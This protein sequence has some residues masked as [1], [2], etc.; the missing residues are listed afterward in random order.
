MK[1]ILI[2]L[3]SLFL[4]SCEKKEEPPCA[5]G[6]E[7]PQENLEWLK[8]QLEN[9]FCTEIYL[10][11][12]NDKEYIGIYD[13]PIGA[14]MGFVIYNC[15]GTKYCQY[16]GL[17]GQCDCTANFLENATKTLIYKQTENPKFD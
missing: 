14:D 8:Q 6:V 4:I 5:C 13:C 12:Y 2:L 7:N 17:S 10:Y 1:Q 15:D 11:K 9:S 16:V 3:I